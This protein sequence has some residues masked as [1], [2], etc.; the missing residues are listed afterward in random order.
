MTDI[1]SP[2]RPIAAPTALV[3]FGIT[4]NLSQIKLLPALYH[5]LKKGLLPEEFVI[6]GVFRQTSMDL[7]HLMQQ[8][9]I[10]LLRKHQEADKA[11]LAQLK[12]MIRTIVMDS[13]RVEDY[14]TLREQLD[15]LDA[16]RNIP[17]QR[18]YY[19]AIPPDIFPRVISNLHDAE[20]HDETSGTARR[21]LV[22]KPFGT[23]LQ[24]A[25]ELVASMSTT[26]DEHQIYRIDHYL[27]KENAQNILTFR[28]GNPLIE[29]LWSR[30]S[31]DHIQITA[32]E[33][34]GID[35]RGNFYEGMG[36]LRDFIQSHLLQ[37]MSL[38]MM[39][40]P[41]DMTSASIHREKLA[42]L[43]SIQPIK[44]NHVD[45]IAV[46]GQYQGYREEVQNDTST[47]ETYAAL[48]L[49]VANSRWG[50]VPVL[51]RTGKALD[52]ARTEI[53]VVFKDRTRRNI[54]EN[55]LTI[56]IQPNEGIALKL[57]AKK[58][59]FDSSLQPVTMKFNYQDTFG[60][61]SPDAYERVLVDTIAGDQSLF[62]T[63]DE[64]IRSWE[65]LEPILEYWQY[66]PATPEM[67]EKGS[68]GPSAADAL[69]KSFGC[70]WL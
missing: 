39:E 25:K 69:A 17:H 36:A 67:Y 21:I 48:C 49:E 59:G 61:D 30:Q 42:L 55:I 10:N 46:R 11:I 33:T 54:P 44:Q 16:E 40:T 56:R 20:L 58:P 15:A 1:S 51:I 65:I 45:E 50:G 57:M 62:A 28:F 66:N 4:G 41:S 14:H 47:T 34:I 32:T 60:G 29:N 13:V 19:L 63:S 7:D 27:A 3:I 31:I 38:V 9:E 70:E 52:A 18:L 12:A 64:V 2:T 22:E 53:N 68:T 37:L 23:N 43:Q 6:V 5:L 8:V 24:T 35:S 26:F